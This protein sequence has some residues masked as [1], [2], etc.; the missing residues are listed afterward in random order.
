MQRVVHA[1]NDR[2]LDLSIFKA[3]KIFSPHNHPNDDSDRFTNT[4]L[5]LKGQLLKFQYPKEENDTCKGKLLEFTE[6]LWYECENKTIFETWRICGSNLEWYTNW[7]KLNLTLAK[8]KGIL[9]PSS[10][11]VCERRF[12]KQNVIKSHLCNRL[13]LKTL[14]ALIRISLCGLKWMQ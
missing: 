10:I 1:L 13:N 14:D 4:K 12:F 3:T 9:I 5:W 6:T 7:P 8:K 2:F 11:V